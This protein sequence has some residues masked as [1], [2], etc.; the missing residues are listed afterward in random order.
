MPIGTQILQGLCQYQVLL[1]IGHLSF[2]QHQPTQSEMTPLVLPKMAKITPSEPHHGLWRPIFWHMP[3]SQDCSVPVGHV[4]NDIGRSATV[5]LAY[6]DG[7]G[8]NAR[9]QPPTRHPSLGALWP[10]IRAQ[11][12]V[13][14]QHHCFAEASI[15]P[16]GVHT[17]LTPSDRSWIGSWE[18]EETKIDLIMC[19]LKKGK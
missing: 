19:I 10:S 5:S 15:D 6:L 14:T 12:S 7:Q 16:L 13:R 17:C 4:T 11:G 8:R 18:H 1:A 9:L 3:L 2:L